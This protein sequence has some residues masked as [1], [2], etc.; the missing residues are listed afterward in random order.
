MVA[1]SRRLLEDKPP[2]SPPAPAPEPPPLVFEDDVAKWKREAD[3]ASAIREANRA[4]LRRKQDDP[5]L[6]GFAAIGSRVSDL[7]Q[8]VDELE[9]TVSAL[10]EVA[11]A[12][13]Q[14][15]E[16]AVTKLTGL[17]ALTARLD[18]VLESMREAREHEMKILNARLT[19]IEAAGAREA[20]FQARQLAAARAELEALTNQLARERDHEHTRKDIAALNDQVSNVVTFM[21]EKRDGAA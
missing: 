17:E 15:S 20:A 18:R 4:E 14:F 12:A 3:E 1:E 7:E 13:A 6:A 10:Y 16:A 19:A 9:R 8:R 2:T 11:P 21:T 5:T